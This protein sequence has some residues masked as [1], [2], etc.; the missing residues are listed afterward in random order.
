MSSLTT[1]LQNIADI[2]DSIT[3]ERETAEAERQHLLSR[4]DDIGAA[5]GD[6]R[7]Q[8]DTLYS[9]RQVALVNLDGGNGSPVSSAT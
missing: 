6:L 9:Q 7:V 2:R 8:V 1:L 3:A 4:I 5:L